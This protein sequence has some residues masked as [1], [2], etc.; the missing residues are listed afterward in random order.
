MMRLIE[1]ATFGGQGKGS[2]DCDEKLSEDNMLVDAIKKWL[3]IGK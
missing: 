2:G 1:G 3:N